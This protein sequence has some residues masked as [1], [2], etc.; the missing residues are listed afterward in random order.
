[1]PITFR[2]DAA[3]VVPPSNAATRKYGQSLVLQQQQ[4]KYQGQQAGYD[5]QFQLGR[6]WQQ[7]AFQVNRANQQNQFQADRDIWQNAQEMT[8]DNTKFLQQQQQQRAADFAAARN[9]IDTHAQDMLNSGQ[10]T[11]PQLAKRVRELV[12]GKRAIM[13][14]GFNETQQ[15]EYLDKYNAELA[16]IL[17][18]VPAPPPKPT[19]QEQF[20]QGV[21]VD[22][23]TGMRYR[24]NAKGDYEPLP[25]PVQ[26]PQKPTSADEAFQADPKTRDKY[27]EDA[28]AIV[29]KG[30][31]EPLTRESRKEAADLAKQ[32]Y[33]EEHRL[34]I[35]NTGD[36]TPAP[37]LPGAEGSV[38]P[39]PMQSILETPSAGIPITPP[40]EGRPPA[41]Q[42]SASAQQSSEA[43]FD[44]ANQAGTVSEPAPQ[45]GPLPLTS[46]LTSQT[47]P[48]DVAGGDVAQPA[49]QAANRREVKV[50]G[51]PLAVTPGTL[52][53]QETEAR[54]SFME[55]PREQRIA[56][57]M[58]YDSELKGKTLEQLLESPETKAQYEELTKQGLTT[59]N[60]REDML[61]HLDEMLQHN[62]LNNAGQSPPSA[63]VGMRADEITDP[64]AKAEVAKLPRPK[65]KN[66]RDA[67]RSGQLYVDPEGVI[68]ARA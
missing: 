32:L 36:P 18:E 21:V 27:M 22:P 61:G 62:V 24:Q 56:A 28:K 44:A 50:G 26:Q 4:Q 67:I 64:K 16:K 48:A 20:D 17:S 13:G 40:D 7:N 23:N 34:G 37:L 42:T 66:D 51:K 57:L 68:R 59:G 29:T 10:I 43:D 52:T 1:M 49:P 63:Y 54:S 39:G 41:P 15:Q 25:E 6:D 53:P 9:R 60:Y 8:R 19:A 38:A 3:A 14:S 58:P 55:L 12:D 11:D 46:N 47:E 2:H 33:E 30:G 31:E 45:R 35:Y 5:R 65:A